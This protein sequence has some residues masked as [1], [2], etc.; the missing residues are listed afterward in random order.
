[1]FGLNRPNTARWLLPCVAVHIFTLLLIGCDDGSNRQTITPPVKAEPIFFSAGPDF[2]VVPI[3]WHVTETTHPNFEVTEWTAYPADGYHLV[4]VY[5]KNAEDSFSLSETHLMVW[6]GQH[7]MLPLGR[8]KLSSREDTGYLFIGPAGSR[9]YRA[10][11]AAPWSDHVQLSTTLVGRSVPGKTLYSSGSSTHAI[12]ILMHGPSAKDPAVLDALEAIATGQSTFMETEGSASQTDRRSTVRTRVMS[13]QDSYRH[14]AQCAVALWLLSDG[15]RFEPLSAILE[16]Q[17]RRVATQGPEYMPPSPGVMD[18]Y[19]LREKSLLNP[20]VLA[21]DGLTLDE[22]KLEVQKLETLYRS[23]TKDVPFIYPPIAGGFPSNRANF[24]L[25]PFMHTIRQLEDQ[26]DLDQLLIQ[27]VKS[28][29]EPVSL[30]AGESLQKRLV[31][32]LSRGLYRWREMESIMERSSD[33]AEHAPTE[34]QVRMMIEQ[35]RTKRVIEHLEYLMAVI[36]Q[37]PNKRATRIVV[38]RVR[39]NVHGIQKKDQPT[40]PFGSDQFPLILKHWQANPEIQKISVMLEQFDQWAE[41][42]PLTEEDRQMSNT[43]QAWSSSASE[44]AQ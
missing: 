6:A 41:A 42:N 26:D 11:I 18:S 14:R 37:A 2:E 30:M 32:E 35:L 10:M 21:E 1:M 27:M 5:P 28:D 19:E 15:D 7:A 4:I 20:V 22:M 36:E 29:V 24:P 3:D 38:H 39:E 17:H 44:R 25:H 13:A 23:V 9:D 8:S 31:K 12:H 40:G 43:G 16:E 33:G 34:A